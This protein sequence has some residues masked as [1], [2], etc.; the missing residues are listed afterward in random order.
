MTS[1]FTMDYGVG[2][3]GG[4][5]AVALLPPDYISREAGSRGHGEMHGRPEGRGRGQQ[6]KWKN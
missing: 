2:R 5:W 3:G 1:P 6:L 4:M